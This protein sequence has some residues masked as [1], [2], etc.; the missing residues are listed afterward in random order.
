MQFPAAPSGPS[1]FRVLRGR[2]RK[3][4]RLLR[5]CRS[6]LSLTKGSTWATNIFKAGD[7][8][9]PESLMKLTCSQS[10]ARHEVQPSQGIN[11]CTPGGAVAP[12]LSSSQ[13]GLLGPEAF[14]AEPAQK[15]GDVL[16]GG[17]CFR[18]PHLTVG[19]L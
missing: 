9:R 13:D 3:K 5:R 10:N 7:K 8:A 12:Q 19:S 16:G 18:G 4:T 17:P 15:Q 2:M 6:I 11:G 1:A 14:D